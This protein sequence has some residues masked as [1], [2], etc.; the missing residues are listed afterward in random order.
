[1]FADSRR[2]YFVPTRER[3]IGAR[4]TA[5]GV[6]IGGRI[7]S[8]RQ[9]LLSTLKGPSPGERLDEPTYVTPFHCGP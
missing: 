3:R 5:A 6:V 4:R 7:V 8:H 2:T 1:M 9:H